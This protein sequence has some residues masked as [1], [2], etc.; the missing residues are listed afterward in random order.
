[1]KGLLFYFGG[2]YIVLIYE[3][4]LIDGVDYLFLEWKSGDYIYWYVKLVYYVMCRV[5]QQNMFVIVGCYVDGI[6]VFGGKV[7]GFFW[8]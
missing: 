8:D 2:D 6:W 7:M 1:M 3:I 5:D 4:K